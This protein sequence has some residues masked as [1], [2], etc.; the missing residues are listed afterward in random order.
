V[1]F[2]IACTGE[3]GVD[4]APRPAATGK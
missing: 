2:R 1:G 3:A 4:G